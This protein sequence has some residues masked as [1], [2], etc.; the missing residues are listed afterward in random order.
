MRRMGGRVLACALFVVAAADGAGAQCPAIDFEDLAVGTAVTT[1]YE[2][3]TFSVQPQS[4][5]GLPTLYMR[6]VAPAGGTSSG[7]QALRIDTGC[8]DFSSDY[9]RMVFDDLQRYVT[10]TVGEGSGSAGWDFDVRYYSDSALLG[11]ISMESAGGVY[12]LVR[13]GSETGIQNIRRIEIDQPIDGWEV[14]DDLTFNVDA[15]PPIARIDAP[16]YEGCACD[17]VSVTGEAC[18]DDGDYGMDKLE[19]RSVNAAPDDPWILIGSYTTPVCGSG[20]LYSW[21]TEDVTHGKYYLK[22]TVENACGAQAAAV[23]V[24]YVDKQ[25]DTVTVRFPQEDQVVGGT[26]CIDGTVWDENCFD[27]YTVEY[28]S[29]GIYLPVD[30]AHV[31]YDAYVVNDPFAAWNT[32]AGIADGSYP[33]RVIGTGVCGDTETAYR[34]AVVDNTLP[35]ALITAPDGCERLEGLIEVIGTASD[36]HLASWILDY[37]GGDL[38]GWETIASGTGTISDDVLG[39]W[40]TTG[41]ADCAYT[42]RLRV[43]DSAVLDCNYTA[44]NMAMYTTSVEVGLAAAFDADNDSDVDL[45][46]YSEFQEVFTGPHD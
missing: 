21:D 10:F 8:P 28:N 19:Y 23:T 18:D 35:T 22:L 38:H 1:Q 37:T 24:A 33:L 11:T 36:A 27:H 39:L 43:W 20:T 13:V 14:I 42:L 9:A 5:G 16:A 25:F 17:T 46:D 6:I 41:L 40:D 7:T 12:R 34:D 4:C 30:P 26:V 45:V 3:V 15:T 29:G 31:E 44:H 2:G 32:R